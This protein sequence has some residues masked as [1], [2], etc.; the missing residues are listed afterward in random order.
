MPEE[1]FN[2]SAAAIRKMEEL[3]G[4]NG[5]F[6]KQSMRRALRMAAK[7]IRVYML[8]VIPAQTGLTRVAVKVRAGKRSRV[9]ISMLVGVFGLARK[10][11]LM[12]FFA[13]FA[14][15]GHKTPSGEKIPGIEWTEPVKSILPQAANNIGA[16]LGEEAAA[17]ARAQ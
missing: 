14:N 7:D 13:G 3:A 17:I 8:S 6:V 16:T 4:E 9:G 15:Y 2:G 12:R 11:P 1:G 5:K 10:G